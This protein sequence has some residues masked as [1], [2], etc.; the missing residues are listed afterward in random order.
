MSSGRALPL[1]QDTGEARAWSSW[2]VVY[3]DV[4]IL[5]AENEKAGVY[6]LTQHDLRDSS[7]FEALKEMLLEA[8]SE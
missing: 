6:N 7:N 4:V 3:R 5:G 1:L 2:E 8:A